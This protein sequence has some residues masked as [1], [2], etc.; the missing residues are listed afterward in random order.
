MGGRQRQKIYRR[1][2]V[3]DIFSSDISENLV[4]RMPL[5]IYIRFEQYGYGQLSLFQ[6]QINQYWSVTI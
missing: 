1:Y 6:Y 2:P 5:Y 4:E 3:F